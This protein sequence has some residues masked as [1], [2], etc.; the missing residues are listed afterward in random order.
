MSGKEEVLTDD[1]HEIAGKTMREIVDERKKHFANR[2]DEEA[3]IEAVVDKEGEVVAQRW[4][5]LDY[6]GAVPQYRGIPTTR[7][8]NKMTRKEIAH[9]IPKLM[10]TQD[11]QARATARLYTLLKT[12]NIKVLEYTRQVEMMT[13]LF[14]ELFEE[15]KSEFWWFNDMGVSL[16]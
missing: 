9:W 6:D 5:W 11:G 8:C 14:D 13:S 1:E 12:T 2:E 3:G 7:E 15:D 16:L 10:L 4:P